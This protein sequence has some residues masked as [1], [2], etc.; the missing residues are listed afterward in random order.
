MHTH[1]GACLVAGVRRRRARA[2]VI[3]QLYSQTRRPTHEHSQATKTRQKEKTHEAQTRGMTQ[4][5]RHL[6]SVLWLAGSHHTGPSALRA[7]SITRA[8]VHTRE[9]GGA[10]RAHSQ[11]AA[12]PAARIV[13][14]THMPSSRPQVTPRHPPSRIFR[15]RQ[16][17]IHTPPPQLAKSS[18]PACM[19]RSFGHVYRKSRTASME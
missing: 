1:T 7:R 11:R 15:R 10:A 13:R 19:H 2:H 4:L 5:Y 12:P 18:A 6:I 8:H 3:R 14:A 16:V 17:A 9:C